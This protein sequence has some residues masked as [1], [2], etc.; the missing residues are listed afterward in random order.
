MDI[1]DDIDIYLPKY[2][3][4]ESFASLKEEL[5][6][7]PVDGTK[8]TIYTTQFY[9]DEILFQGDG[10]TSLKFV[11]MELEEFYPA[12]AILLSNTCDMDL[13]NTRAFFSPNI[14]YAPIFNLDKYRNMIYNSSI[15][16]EIKE[17]K[18]GIISNEEKIKIRKSIDNHIQEIK[19]QRITQILYLPKGAG[20][21]YE[22]IVFLD[23]I[24]HRDSY[25]IERN[26]LQKDRLF[27][28]SNY[29]LYLFLLKIAIHFTRIQEKVDRYT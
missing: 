17:S 27:I 22:G 23:Q 6:K 9:E 3:S 8:A 5:K 12:P 24:S 15:E 16:D 28:L 25:Q 21:T 4:T 18:T 14:C 7:F 1:L 10:I 11:D 2:L 19:L 26:N 20:L 13:A 29:G